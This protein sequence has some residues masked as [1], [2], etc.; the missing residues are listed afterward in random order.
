MSTSRL[1]GLSTL[2][3]LLVTI[4]TLTN[5]GRYHIIDE[6]S[7]YAVTESLVLHGAMDT[8]AIAWTQWVNSPGEVLGAFGPD[9]QVY[10]KKGPAPA[11]VATLWYRLLRWVALLD[12]RIG[13][14]Q[15]TLLWN[16][17][18]TA[19]T[20]AL[21]WLTALR[22]GYRDRTGAALALLFGLGTIA[23]PYAKHFFGE[24]LSALSLLLCFYGLESYRH[25]PQTRWLW[26]AGV[27][28]GVAVAT[29]TAHVLLVA[30][31]GIYALGVILFNLQQP[32]LWQRQPDAEEVETTQFTSNVPPRPARRLLH[33]ISG[34]LAFA[35]PL[36]AAGLFLLWYNLARFGDLWTTGYHFESGEGFTTP[37][38][39]GLW[40]LLLSPY[41]GVFWHTPLLLLAAIS[42]RSFIRRHPGEGWLITLLALT[43]VLLYSRW[44]MWWG[45]FAW[46]PRFLVPL[47]PFGVLLLAPMVASGGFYIPVVHPPWR[48]RPRFRLPRL[49]PK[50]WLFLSLTLLS[51]V[52]QLLA[53]TVNY[54]VYE[55]K[56][57]TEY[58]PTDMADPLKF[59]PPAQ[60]LGDWL[61]SPVVG[62]WQLLREDFR[63]YSDLAWLWPDG[64]VQWVVVII[65]LAVLL[66]QA[67]AG[68]GWW[69]SQTSPRPPEPVSFFVIGALPLLS[70][71]CMGVW[72]GESSKSPRYGTA[73]QGFQAI[74][75]EICAQSRPTDVLVTVAPND[76]HIPMNW[77]GGRC[78][79]PPYVFGYAPNSL[80]YPETQQV[81]ERLVQVY[82]RIWF[83]TAG[84]PVNDADNTLERW[85]ATVAY[86]ADD[87]WFDNYRLVRY[88]VDVSVRE[89]LNNPLDLFLEDD[90]G[91]QVT[92]Q[93]V[94]S[95]ATAAGGSIL[96][97]ELTYQVETATAANLHW[98]VQL[99]TRDGSVVAQID[100]APDD[101]YTPF[102]ALPVGEPVVE[103]AGLP[104]P[105]KLPVD[106][107]RLI[108]GLY[109]PDAPNAPRL[110]MP[111]GRDY[112]DLGFVVIQ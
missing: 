91:L 65:G 87:R 112:V 93:T 4:Y 94:R 37:L 58:F 38:L 97:V 104:L 46:G 61:Y 55:I 92:L 98:F 1:Y 14:L 57:R 108:A 74:L 78:T 71:L 34:L 76:Y 83:V 59:G 21:L 60:G 31:L 5:A 3:A 79:H 86:K 67:L 26:L 100:T 40:G 107:Y 64:T 36:V 111:T 9:G 89:A 52:V 8:N 73:E 63:A 95:L 41:R 101:G 62:Q 18:I 39:Q 81:L 32:D 50:G 43:L 35:L 19:A 53:V 16:G 105:E 33:V 88:G 47:T 11:F 45:G 48:R 44:W 72:L 20:A 25:T 2:L 70:L 54:E 22:L 75:A 82:D 49:T 110:T 77:L 28:A 17:F 42:W 106:Q 103:R 96:P 102:S 15:G 69:R 84:L 10:S 85:L 80:Q 7:L 23:W 68:W 99:L 66:T 109:N 90:Q 6:V 13:L 24:P 27:G 56:L 51:L 12:I 30:L 29:V